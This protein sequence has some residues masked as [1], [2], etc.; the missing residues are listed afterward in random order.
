MFNQPILLLLCEFFVFQVE[1]GDIIVK[2]NGTDVHRFTTKE[3]TLHI[4]LLSIF[5]KFIISQKK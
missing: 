2:V 3:G 5:S 1:A 4:F